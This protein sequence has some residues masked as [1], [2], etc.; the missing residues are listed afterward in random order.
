MEGR[1]DDLLRDKLAALDGR[2]IPGA[3]PDWE[4]LRARLDGEAFDAPLREALAP[5]PRPAVPG[6]APLIPGWDRLAD[7]LDAEVPQPR[8]AAEGEAFDD[9]LADKLRRGAAPADHADATASWRR[10]SHRMDTFWPLRRRLL[11]Y[12][13]L[14]VAAAAAVVL[15]LLP[16][17]RE[18]VIGTMPVGRPAIAS[19]TPGAADAA[20]VASDRAGV[21]SAWDRDATSP[22]VAAE[23]DPRQAL[24]DA[25]ARAGA[26]PRPA[27]AAAP[28]PLPTPMSLLR[29]AYGWLSGVAGADDA[30]A[31]SPGVGPGRA[32]ALLAEAHAGRQTPARAVGP[33]RY[34]VA[35]PLPVAAVPAVTSAAAGLP[36]APPVAAAAA[37][38]PWR[39]AVEAG[40]SV[41]QVRTPARPNLRLDAAVAREAGLG[42]QATLTRALGAR[43]ELGFGL[44][45]ATIDYDPDFPTLVQDNRFHTASGSLAQSETLERVSVTVAKIPVD[46]R[47]DLLAGPR[48]HGRTRL[49]AKAGLAAN[50]TLGSEYGL[51]RRIG[52]IQTL[53]AAPQ[54]AQPA[55]ESPDGLYSENVSP[56]FFEP[57]GEFSEN[58]FATARVGLE[59]EVLV[60]ERVGLFGAADYDRFLPL[61]DGLGPTDD[62]PSQLGLS[63]GVRV[64]L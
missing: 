45:V 62:Q 20:A 15:T 10:L 40:P 1:L 46:V 31:T 53:S 33:D 54:T 56:G 63:V 29:D 4:R 60:G 36:P 2:R 3:A 30:E 21:P 42:A 22:P 24:P 61:T 13:V 48:G 17:L 7:R 5:A 43:A 49:W 47:Y 16:M 37:H 44:G 26:D 38:R 28:A 57:G 32:A 34:L 55:I 58:A 50:V 23:A 41:W 12:R 25:R 64:S 18:E 39:L 59:A 51:V 8:S 9:L 6:V 52:D 35:D 14:E 27:T 11:R 19:A